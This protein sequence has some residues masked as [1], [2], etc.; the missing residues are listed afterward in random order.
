MRIVEVIDLQNGNLFSSSS[1]VQRAWRDVE[2]AVVATVW[3]HGSAEFTIRPVIKGN[4]VKPI[5]QPCL[6]HLRNQG[7]ET[8]CLPQLGSNVLTPGDLDAMLSVGGRH[9][10]FEWE[11]GNI[12]SSHRAMNKLL[13]GMQQIG[14]SVEAS[15]LVVPSNSLAS[16]LTDRIGNIGELRPYLNL[17]QTIT[18]IHGLLRIVV[19]EYDV[20]DTNGT[21]IPKGRDGMAL[22]PILVASE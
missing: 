2:N 1:L 17:W 15:F 21:L 10:L 5:K 20:V 8:E 3:P 19:V 6:D 9:V 11:T 14:P 22:Q 16:F 12:S 18:N 13:L 7:W 4:G